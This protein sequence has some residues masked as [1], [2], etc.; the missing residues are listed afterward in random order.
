MSSEA[1]TTLTNFEKVKEFNRAFDMR[2]NNEFARD[3]FT[4]DPENV[5][6]ALSLISE[7]VKELEDAV[8]E[9]NFGEVRDAIADIL[10]VVYGMADRFGIDAD[11]DF[12]DVHNSNMSK[13]CNNQAEADATVKF[14]KEKFEKGES[15]YDTPCSY[16][17]TTADGSDRWL[18]KN[19]STGKALKNIN[20][21][22]VNFE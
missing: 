15:K 11:A 4:K 19:K 13:L 8:K 12:A 16:K 5:T 1:K 3:I 17:V 2:I 22:A 7:E 9:H 18:V 20:Y 14:Y 6:L 10:Y 21:R